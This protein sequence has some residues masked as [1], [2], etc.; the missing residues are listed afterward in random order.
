MASQLSLAHPDFAGYAAVRAV[1][2][3]GVVCTAAQA[4]VLWMSPMLTALRC[5]GAMPPP[6]PSA[7]AAAARPPPVQNVHLMQS[8]LPTLERLLETVVESADADFRCFISAE[9]SPIPTLANCPESL[10]QVRLW[11]VGPWGAIGTVDR[12]C[13]P[14]AVVWSPS[15]EGWRQPSTVAACLLFPRL[16]PR[17][18]CSVRLCGLA[19]PPPPAHTV[20]HQSGQRGTVRP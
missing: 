2:L 6:S 12:L 15:C 11:C 19:L 5:G 10:L 17:P 7:I 9:A 4:A 18:N 8:W 1:R 14:L 3:S 13:G 20:L 16:N